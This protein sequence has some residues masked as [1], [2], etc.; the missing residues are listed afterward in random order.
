[1]MRDEPHGAPIPKKFEVS[2]YH[3]KELEKAHETLKQITSRTEEDWYQAWHNYIKVVQAKQL[4]FKERNEST[5]HKYNAI[6][7]QV[8][9]WLPPTP[10]H[11]GLKEFMVEQI[12][13]SL[14]FDCISD[15][16]APKALGFD[17][18]KEMERSSALRDVDYHTR[19]WEAEKRRVAGR[20]KWLEQLRESVPM[21]QAPTPPKAE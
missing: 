12:Q 15:K 6:L 20:N 17:E 3:A 9:D 7:K 4:Q 19:E 18:W 1:M 5:A 10:D 21:P 2:T 14:E 11:Q 8:Q 13:S 16:Y